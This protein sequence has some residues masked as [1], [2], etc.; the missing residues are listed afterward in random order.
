MK[1]SRR[2]R[3]GDHRVF[4]SA[5]WL[6][7]ATLLTAVAHAAAVSVS[8]TE[9][10]TQGDIDGDGRPDLVLVDRG[11]GG[12]RIG[13]QLAPDVFTWSEARATGV[14]DVTGLSVGRV[15]GTT[16][17]SLVV[18][19]PGA[20]RV[21]ILE[22]PT[23]NAVALPTPVW[24]P[25]V[26]PAVALALDI[27]GPGNTAHDDLFC[28]S[29]AN[30]LPSPNRGSLHRSVG[31]AISLIGPVAIAGRPLSAQ[32]TRLKTGGVEFA[33]VVEQQGDQ[34]T[35]RLYNL[36]AGNLSP[37]LTATGLPGAE[38]LAAP[39][40][41]GA[42]FQYLFWSRG[43][44]NLVFRAVQEPNPGTFQFT[45][46]Q[47]WSFDFGIGQVHALTDVGVSR[48]AVVTAD[49]S[50]LVMFDFDGVAAPV[51]VQTLP[52][53]KGQV[54]TGLASLSGGRFKAFHG[55][56]SDRRT[57][58]FTDHQFAD[59][60]YQAGA[61]GGLPAPNATGMAAN[62]FVFDAEPFVVGQARRLLSLN[63]ADW[64]RDPQ[65]VGNP[66]T[67]NVQAERRGSSQQGLG[68]P[69][70]R[71][72][73]TVPAGAT[74]VLANQYRPMIS[75][76]SFLPA[77]GVELAE[78]QIQPPPGIQTGVAYLSFS[79]R[80]ANTEIHFRTGPDA[81]WIQYSGQ[82]LPL[83]RDTTVEFLGRIPGGDRKTAIR[84][85]HY[86]FPGAPLEQDSDGDGVPDFVELGLGTDPWL[87]DTDADGYD[88]R[89]EL[90][91]GT[92]PKNADGMVPDAV[93]V[94]EDR[95]DE[96]ASFD[97]YATPQPLDGVSGNVVVPRSGMRV[98]VHAVDGAFLVGNTNA[99]SVVPGVQQPTAALIPVSVD[100][101]MGLV[102]V[103]TDYH[104]PINTASLDKA[105]GRELL[106]V[107]PV[108][109]VARP[110][111]PYVPGNGSPLV[112]AQA[113]VAA[114]RNTFT[115][116]PRVEVKRNFGVHDTLV[117]ALLERKLGMIFAARGQTNLGPDK[118]TLFPQRDPGSGRNA[119][120]FVEW[121][122]LSD[123]VADALPGWDARALFGG[124]SSSVLPPG[125]A[126]LAPL[127]Q[128]NA[129]I[130]R[131]S[132]LSNNVAP[133]TFALPFD[134]LRGFL[135]TGQL[136]APYAA[137][138]G[139]AP[140]QQA[141][142]HAAAT[143]LLDQLGSRPT[144]T[145][146]LEVLPDSFQ[147]ACVVLR[148][149]P[150]GVFKSLF[151]S[152]DAP[153]RF[154]SSFELIPGSQ[155]RVF[156]FTDLVQETCAGDAL[157]VI[158]AELV[159]VPPLPVVDANANL[160][161]DDWECLFGGTVGDPFGDLDG[162]GYS[163]LQEYLDGTDPG[164]ANS[165][166]VAVV[167]LDVPELEVVLL[168]GEEA[169]IGWAYPPQYAGFMQ[170]K[171]LMTDEFGVPFGEGGIQIQDLGGGKFEVILPVSDLPA[172]FYLLVQ[173]L[174]AAP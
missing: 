108:P 102:T 25:G 88:D 18:A 13:Y 113:W 38:W 8:D 50:E 79:V 63:A 172:G 160:L 118:L 169:K 37:G 120:S 1:L 55:S 98:Q 92:D 145:E 34:R 56:P 43:G 21:Q 64:A 112:E 95:L 33:G 174:K 142:A 16:R 71:P 159:S 52:A 35:L 150:G 94:P 74:H 70:V 60:Q 80:P 140:A 171:L 15:L 14:A 161:P 103:G 30:G 10:S 154:P 84:S 46:A 65:I 28:I 53:P 40:G 59:G 6:H 109:V 106:A 121:L 11:S 3:S 85:A 163:N 20:N 54:W 146:I 141:A 157:Q 147:G 105:I 164:D 5:A 93:P 96:N 82:V 27:G 138:V 87:A 45:P 19:A 67:L 155:V 158:E 83:Y 149:V 114:A 12:V 143:A 72:L 91:A 151:A 17:D 26:G 24:T 107:V 57:R 135:A 73:G 119:P 39:F 100:A 162:D 9:L 32:G 129:A 166:G 23:A 134:V 144:V 81:P 117:A 139:V 127:R 153:Y 167:K 111:I 152:P 69:A 122:E 78:V 29:V 75:V 125:S 76:Q 41:G 62:V 49:G 61:T 104:F 124:I 86:S 48:L 101:R 47:T 31:N 36:S 126:A 148:T 115:N 173:L 170:F 2:F 99:M 165:K 132:S 128:L 168:P 4:R 130:Y 89:T 66:A 110:V 97:L 58:R 77:E 137:V 68:N 116:L 136:P 131:V 90:V 51:H 22:L 7:G 44:S 42:L 156:G 123:W 133:G